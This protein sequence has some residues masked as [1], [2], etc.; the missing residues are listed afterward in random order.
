MDRPQFDFTAR[1]WDTNLEA[2]KEFIRI[3]HPEDWTSFFDGDL[4]TALLEAIAYNSTLLGYTLD[5]Q[6]LESFLDTL[7]LR[8]SAMHFARQNSYQIRRNTSASVPVYASASRAPSTGERF[9]IRQGVQI[10][11]KMGQPWEVA[12]DTFLEEGYVNPTHEILKYGDIK[13]TV[14][15][16]TNVTEVKALVKLEP[17][18]SVATLVDENGERFPSD[19]NFSQRVQAGHILKLGN[20]WNGTSFTSIP[21]PPK[22]EY[23]IISTSKFDYDV[24]DNSI[25][26]L[27]R[28][29]SG[30]AVWSGKWT[31]ESRNVVLIQGESK[32]D[33]ATAPSELESRK[34]YI[35][36]GA[37]F[38]VVMGSLD[39]PTASGSSQLTGVAGSGI[40]V[41]VNGIQ[42]TETVSLLFEGPDSRSF[43]VDFDNNDRFT[44]QFGDGVFGS[45]VP[46]EATIEI[47]YRIGGGSKG[48][49]S[50]NLIDTS[51]T[52]GDSFGSAST[53]IQ[54]YLSNTYTV[55]TGGQ[56]RESLQDLKKNIPAHI[57]TNDRAVTIEDY[58]YLASNFSDPIAGRVKVAKGVIHK[59]LVPREQNIIWVYTW[60]EGS[61]G[62]LT[63]P[64][65][66][67]KRALLEYLN[68]RKLVT[69]EVVI[70]DG[71]V[72]PTP[73]EM[74]YCFE[75]GADSVKV[76]QKVQSAIN[77]I[78]VDLKPGDPLRLSN[79]YEAVEAVAEVKFC[80]F[81]YPSQDLIPA[82]DYE[83]FSNTMQLPSLTR[84]N[85][86]ASAG[87]SAVQVSDPNL[88]VEQG[89]VS[90]FETS[91]TPTTSTVIA[92]TSNTLSLQADQLLEEDYSLNAVV[93]N[94]AYLPYGWQFER[95]I[96][97]FITYSIGNTTSPLVTSNIARKIRQY[98]SQTLR[99]EEPLIRSTLRTL[100]QSIPNVTTSDVR[101]N[102]VDGIAEQVVPSDSEK[103][104]LGVLSI[105]NQ[106]V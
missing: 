59:N 6:A 50:Q 31:I 15:N 13:G 70:V 4:S 99:P 51:I 80:Q 7:Q 25:I 22:D 16:T 9:V 29:W 32:I 61:N 46:S 88:F 37:Y 81:I 18:S 36:E 8:E 95:P 67:L 69:D 87:A 45:L 2:L 27:D 66:T 26:Y 57:R 58:E 79:L 105:N 98:F 30:T 34:N 12:E 1:D 43:Q 94:S 74:R 103:I 102:S 86:A 20:E 93:T 100:V 92:K 96:D 53:S 71:I 101:F 76:E 65:L 52:I 44:V 35:V 41:Y 24:Y 56:D 64:S 72:T 82:N 40:D 63:A 21:S 90:I 89:T 5:R 14:P 47:H 17:G 104:T 10:R 68:A 75:K 28:A 54:L 73:I 19:I 85:A 11:D 77:Q 3:R 106:I 33:R 83:L 23:A 39:T 49:I 38:P 60:V 91:K 55:G 84:L 97:I 48:N 78:F 62:Q 42:W